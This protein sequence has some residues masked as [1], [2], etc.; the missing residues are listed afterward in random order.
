MGR[1]KGVESL[2]RLKQG[3]ERAARLELQRVN[4][5]IMRTEE[6]LQT[7]AGERRSERRKLAETLAAGIRGADLLL[8]SEAALEAQEK[9][10]FAKLR[11][12]RQLAAQAEG[13]Y[14]E[15]HRERKILE[16][17][18]ERRNQQMEKDGARREQNATDGD[19][20]RRAGREVLS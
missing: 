8:Y 9:V 6:M 4:A 12:L 13:K 14:S 2:Y 17:V 11:E 16:N 3:L 7:L 15:C 20:L 10:G 18:L 19:T 1:G 5:E